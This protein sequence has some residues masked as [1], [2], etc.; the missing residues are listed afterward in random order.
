MWSN[1]LLLLHT[2]GDAAGT[3]ITPE[4]T[5]LEASQ[6]LDAIPSFSLFA[7]GLTTAADGWGE[8][9]L[10]PMAVEGESAASVAEAV[11]AEPPTAAPLPEARSIR[12]LG[13]GQKSAEAPYFQRCVQRCVDT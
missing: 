9:G 2:E 1:R 11:L 3:P 10:R 5:A 6:Q 7:S 8:A 13:T 4:L 12:G